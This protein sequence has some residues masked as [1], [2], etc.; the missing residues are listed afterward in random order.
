MYKQL[1]IYGIDIYTDQHTQLIAVHVGCNTE[2]SCKAEED[3]QQLLFIGRCLH[4]TDYFSCCLSY[5]RADM[6]GDGHTG[7]CT[8]IAQDIGL[9]SGSIPSP[10]CDGIFCY[11]D[12]YRSIYGR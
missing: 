7:E 3:E 6:S 11:L 8:K 9:P 4:S 1:S 12:Y 10:Q 2:F 5:R